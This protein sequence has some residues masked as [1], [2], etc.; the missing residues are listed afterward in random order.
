MREKPRW[1]WGTV[2]PA[3]PGSR[4]HLGCPAPMPWLL[5]V[6]QLAVLLQKPVLRLTLQCERGSADQ[7]A[8]GM[9]LEDRGVR[10]QGPT[11]WFPTSSGCWAPS[12]EVLLMGAKHPY[13]L[14]WSRDLGKFFSNRVLSRLSACVA[15]LVASA[16]SEMAH[17][18]GVTRGP[19]EVETVSMGVVVPGDATDAH[20]ESEGQLRHLTFH[21]GRRGSG[22]G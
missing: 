9:L 6:Q 5:E 16:P 19:H 21:L 20:G 7:Q 1:A 22:S 13:L 8:L 2:P 4:L 18:D 3:C 10:G 14:V 12:G 15:S 11:S 17:R